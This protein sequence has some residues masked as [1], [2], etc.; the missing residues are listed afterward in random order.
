MVCFRGAN[1][2][3]VPANECIKM[4]FQAYTNAGFVRLSGGL[5]AAV[6]FLRESL[7]PSLSPLLQGCIP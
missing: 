7:A 5:L 3:S 4:L 2:R 6:F 1:A